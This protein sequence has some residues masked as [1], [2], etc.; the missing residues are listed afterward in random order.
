MITPARDIGIK[1]EGDLE[2]VEHQVIIPDKKTNSQQSVKT[3]V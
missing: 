2:C 3:A 1:A